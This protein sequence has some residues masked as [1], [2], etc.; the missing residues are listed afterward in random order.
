M[1]ISEA[2]AAET[3]ADLGEIARFVPLRDCGHS[4]LVDDPA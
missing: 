2:M 3:L 4:P 1:V